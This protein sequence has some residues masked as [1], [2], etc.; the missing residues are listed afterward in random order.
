MIG[1]PKFAQRIQAAGV[2]AI[3]LAQDYARLA[4]IVE[5]QPLPE[6][7]SRDPDDD[8]VLATALAAQAN[9]IV[10]GDDDLL[11]LHEYQGMPILPA[12]AALQR[13]SAE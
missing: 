13:L 3:A 9:L 10:S 11:T 4:Q 7:A 1:R 5:P 8:V 2:P 12:S 6:P